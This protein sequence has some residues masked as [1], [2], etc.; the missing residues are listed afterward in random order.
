MAL[1]ALYGVGFA[2]ERTYHWPEDVNKKF[3]AAVNRGV[4]ILG[5]RTS[6]HAF[7]G[8]PKESPFAKW[9]SGNKHLP[10]YI[11]FI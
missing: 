3:E 10:S 11:H 2:W 8:I 7:N 9:N 6:T 5:L 1:F 4:P